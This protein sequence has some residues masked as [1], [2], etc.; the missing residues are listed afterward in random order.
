MGP[1]EADELLMVRWSAQLCVLGLEARRVQRDEAAR[2]VEENSRVGCRELES[3][4]QARD[5]EATVDEDRIPPTGR[6]VLADRVDVGP[7]GPGA[8]RVG[9]VAQPR[10]G[11]AGAADRL[12]L[13]CEAPVLEGA[14]RDRAAGERRR[15]HAAT[16]RGEVLHGDGAPPPR[17]RTREAVGGP[18]RAPLE[19]TR[20]ARLVDQLADQLDFG[21]LHHVLQL[22]RMRVA[23]ALERAAS[24]SA[25]A[26]DDDRPTDHTQNAA[27]DCQALPR[28]R[29]VAGGHDQ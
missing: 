9:V 26:P 27:P 18:A 20:R 22:L 2:I 14:R 11:V 3:L 13:G 4:E 24:R 28:R 6:C 29:S 10:C 8:R 5:A 1:V 16:P 17:Q 15:A 25:R 12:I 23:A 7:E 21:W 19:V